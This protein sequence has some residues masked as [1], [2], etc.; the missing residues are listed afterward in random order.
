LN[1]PEAALFGELPK[2]LGKTFLIGYLLPAA[3]LLLGG[4]ALSDFFLHAGFHDHVVAFFAVNDEKVLAFRLGLSVAVAWVAGVV[5][6]SINH[7][8]IR[9][10][11]GYGRFN[12][13][14]LL[15][16]RST[17]V[18]D[19]LTAEHA[20]IETQRVSG[21]IPQALVAS[22]FLVR[23]R[24][25]NEFPE[26]RRLLLPTRFG[27][28]LRAFERYPQVIYSMDSIHIWPRLQALIPENYRSLLD[29]AKAQLDFWVNLWFSFL[30]LA[31]GTLAIFIYARNYT[32]GPTNY[33][34]GAVSAAA[35][36]LAIGAAK[37]AQTAAAQWGMLV[38]GAFD[39]YRGELCKQ[40]G[41]DMPQSLEDERQMWR[42]VSQTF[43][44]RRAEYA[45]DLTRFRPRKNEES[46][47]SLWAKICALFS[48][49]NSPPDSR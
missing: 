40:L 22:H 8:L 32:L 13:A 28:V 12:P 19:R 26:Q 47:A 7:N 36:I 49:R 29:D 35:V 20:A 18:F 2:L 11:E 45:D 5:L 21:K 48:Y 37:L 23:Y 24:L 3:V 15:K 42:R 6:L 43:L 31:L 10:L 33:T 41:L 1:G 46:R 34:L 30:L 39:L 9:L 38:K 25:G 44:L 16:S 27:N 17:A 14:R 4:A